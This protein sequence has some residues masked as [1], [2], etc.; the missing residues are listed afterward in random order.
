MID[1]ELRIVTGGDPLGLFPAR[2]A[3]GAINTDGIGPHSDY[4]A[5][6]PYLGVPH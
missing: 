1:I 2:D 6:F 5:T 3:D 4:L